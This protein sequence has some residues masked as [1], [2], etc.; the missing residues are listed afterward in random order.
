M[1]KKQ[2]QRQTIRNKNA[3]QRKHSKWRNGMEHEK[4][5]QIPRQSER[6]IKWIAAL[7]AS[8]IRIRLY[9]Y[10]I[11]FRPHLDKYIFDSVRLVCSSNCYIDFSI[12]MCL[13]EVHRTDKNS[14]FFYINNALKEKKQRTKRNKTQKMNCALGA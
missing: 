5:Q 3:L 8:D 14:Q 1:E 13:F 12:V 11:V 10:R 6:R 9:V 2:Q 4:K 7:K